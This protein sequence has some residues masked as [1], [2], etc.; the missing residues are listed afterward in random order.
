MPHGNLSTQ[1]KTP[2]LPP[3]V[4]RPEAA[5][6]GHSGPLSLTSLPRPA[7]DLI[8]LGDLTGRYASGSYT[9]LARDGQSVT[10]RQDRQGASDHGHRITAAIACHVARAR[11]SADELVRLLMQP[12][13]EGGRHVRTI[14]ARSGHAR[15]LDYVQRVWESACALVGGTV[16]V[17]SRHQL[18]EGLAALRARIETTPWRGERGR[19]ALRVLLAHL[20]FAETAGGRRHGASERQTAESAGISRPALRSAYASVLW[21]AG[22]LRRLKV[23]HGTE[24]S[25]WYLG[26]GPGTSATAARS[27][28]Q[29]TQFPPD[30]ELEEWSPSGTPSTADLDSTVISRLM[31]HDAFAEHGLGSSAL[32]ILAALRANPHRGAGDL[33]ASSSTSRA[34]TYRTLRRL[35]DLGLVERCG[36]VWDL[37]PGALEGI[38]GDSGIHDPRISGWDAI[39]AQCGTAGFGEQRRL[40]HAAERAAYRAALEH[41]ASHRRRALVIV[42]DGHRL[43]VPSVRPDEIPPAWHA[44]GG[45]VVDPSTGLVAPGWRVAT[46][47]RLIHIGPNDERSYD[48]LAAAH[49]EAVLAWESAA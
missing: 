14:A 19:T 26:D 7:A 4:R 39:A 6:G 44:P 36:S 18:H 32:V 22:W 3:A 30:A 1:L 47:G 2:A 42:R 9:R 31:T 12:D 17:E 5:R 45:A 49:A 38:A 10:P 25:T 24:G 29:T 35:A 37:T 33:V 21:P 28:L 15:A 23:G 34:T 43:V 11:G 40:F 16:E 13:H 41:R 8:L 27:H 46:D 20:S 48:E